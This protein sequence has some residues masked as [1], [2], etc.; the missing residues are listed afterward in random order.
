MNTDVPTHCFILALCVY[1]REG[2]FAEC[3]HAN[4]YNETGSTYTLLDTGRT[5]TKKQGVQ[6]YKS[7]KKTWVAASLKS[8]EA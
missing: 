6:G 8:S 2:V 5:R 3:R 1:S 4:P 7:N